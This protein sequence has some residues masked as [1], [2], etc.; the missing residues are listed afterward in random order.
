MIHPSDREAS[1]PD[2]VRQTSRRRGHRRIDLQ[3][4]IQVYRVGSDAPINAISQDLSWGGAQFL[5]TVPVGWM[6][7]RLR[8]ALPWARGEQLVIDA[9][10][11]RAQQMKAGL[12]QVAVRFSSL[13][14]R[15]QSRLEKLLKMLDP[16]SS[17]SGTIAEPLVKGL[18][19]NI[20]DPG[21]MRDLLEQIAAGQLSVDV[22]KGVD[23]HQS[24]CLKIGGSPDLPT[25]KL[26]ARVLKVERVPA[27]VLAHGELCRLVLEF[28]HPPDSVHALASLLI[29]E[30]WP[31][32]TLRSPGHWGASDRG[33][34]VVHLASPFAMSTGADGGPGD[35]SVLEGRYSD[36]LDRLT[37]VWGDPLA[38]DRIFKDLTIGSRAEPGG[39]PPDAW[40]ELGFLQD[41]HDLAYGVPSFRASD[42]RPG[43]VG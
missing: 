3:I 41:V 25:L 40:E 37:L 6:V 13:T 21:E 22:L 35:G 15:D 10:V 24:L 5:A 7:G 26:R 32:A 34:P 28:E 4:P 1:A 27:R 19:L 38:F 17:S 23:V 11:V 16:E 30:L 36:T 2:S 9:D 33:V 20:L 8:L 12:S 31:G 42:L 29:E 39:W 18:E 43:R 14:A